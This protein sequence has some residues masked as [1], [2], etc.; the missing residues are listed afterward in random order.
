MEPKNDW[1]D[2]QLAKL[3]PDSEWQPQVASAL[4]R[5]EGRRVKPSFIGAWQGSLSL[6]AAAAICIIAFPAP[7]AFAQRIISPY[8]ES[9]TALL[10]SAGDIDFSPNHIFATFHHWLNLAPPDD[11]LTDSSGARFRLSD[12]NGKVVLLSFWS[13]QCAACLKEIPWFMEFQSTYG[14]DK[15]AVIGI[16]LDQGGWKAV[17][18]FLATH[19]LNYRIGVG[20]DVWASQFGGADRIPAAMLLNRKGLIVAKHSGVHEKAD[21]ER[22]IREAVN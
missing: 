17:R 6:A 10:L 19:N 1:V 14:K 11:V 16:S 13:T 7:R 3:N 8:V 22:K 4:T 5:F 2:R 18:P 9:G 12:Y 15:F 21:Y 20:D